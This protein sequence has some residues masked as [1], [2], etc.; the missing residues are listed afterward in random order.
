[1]WRKFMGDHSLVVPLK[2]VSIADFMS[3]EDVSMRMLDQQVCWLKTSEVALVKILWKNQKSGE[4][5]WEV[6]QDMKSKYMYLFSV[7]KTH[8]WGMC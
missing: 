1:M 8:D 4:A 3:Y 7:P 2:D 5:T 6:E